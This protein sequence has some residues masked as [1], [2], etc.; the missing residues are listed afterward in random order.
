MDIYSKYR[1]LLPRERV[2]ELSKLKPSI[3]IRDTII[4][5]SIIITAFIIIYFYTIWWVVLLMI[6]IVGSTYYSLFIIGHDG[7]HQRLFKE[8]KTNDLFC[9]VFIFGF[10]GAIT[11]I[12]KT[13]HLNHHRYLSTE[14]DPDRYK[15][16]C[17]GKETT[18]TV[19]FFLAGFQTFYNTFINVLLKKHEQSI[20]PNPEKIKYKIRDIIILLFCQLLLIGGLTYFIG[21]WAYPIL[22]LL[23]FYIFTF[24]A[25]N[26]RAF[27]NI[28]IL[29]IIPWQINIV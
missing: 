28:L 11:R 9:D 20:N 25:D 8:K 27:P 12:N 18:I 23:P 17:V 13:N 26:F 1:D 7:M 22:W 16:S 2:N 6:P 4:S 14:M 24:C 3:V 29:K 19:F 10:I 21:W 15:Y 5:W